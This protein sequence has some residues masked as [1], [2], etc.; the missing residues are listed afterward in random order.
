L[1][2]RTQPPIQHPVT[3]EGNR[4]TMPWALFFNFLFSGDIGTSWTPIFENL[5][6]TGTPVYEGRYI[7]LTSNLAFFRINVN[8]NGGNST[9]TAGSTAINNF[10]LPFSQNGI[11]FAVSG[12]TGSNAGM[13]DA[14]TRKIFVPSWTSVSVGLTIIGLVEVQ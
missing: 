14:A 11:C 8:P 1:S 5:A 13:V 3:D 9:S 2:N 4:A 12:Y 10:P 6:V 7:L